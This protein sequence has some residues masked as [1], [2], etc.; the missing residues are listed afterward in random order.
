MEDMSVMPQAERMAEVPVTNAPVEMVV[1]EVPMRVPS[2]AQGWFEQLQEKFPGYP[3]WALEL[4]VFGLGALIAGFL[5]KCCGRFVAMVF[6]AL[7]VVLAVLHYAHIMPFNF[8]FFG[9][10]D[11]HSLNELFQACF[12]WGKA[13]VI[14]CVSAVVGFLI[15]WKLG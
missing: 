1:E 15:G 2:L 14:A 10:Q 7:V 11:I 4:V 6:I 8:A 9:L 12:A 3:S 13:H 5:L